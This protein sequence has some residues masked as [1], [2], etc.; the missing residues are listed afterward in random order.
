[1]TFFGPKKFT[2]LHCF[3][4]LYRYNVCKWFAIVRFMDMQNVY[5][6]HTIYRVF[7]KKYLQ[8]CHGTYRLHAHC[9]HLFSLNCNTW[10]PW[11]L[12]TSFWLSK[13]ITA[14]S[15]GPCK[16]WPYGHHLHRPWQWAGTSPTDARH[17]CT[18]HH[19]I[20]G[21]V[22]QPLAHFLAECGLGHI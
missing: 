19:S 9:H 22:H 12:H 11:Q 8:I 18:W 15:L 7:T 6:I 14:R 17:A 21:Q 10:S 5:H 2:S 20:K 3:V 13:P 4:L 16:W 1:M